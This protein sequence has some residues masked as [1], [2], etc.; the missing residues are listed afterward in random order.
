MSQKET[1]AGSVSLT[2][3]ELTE[4]CVHYRDPPFEKHWLTAGCGTDDNIVQTLL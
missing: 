4:L 2:E 1:A 3:L